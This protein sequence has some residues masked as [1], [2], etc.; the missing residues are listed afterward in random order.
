MDN[1]LYKR[2]NRKMRGMIQVH[3]DF[4]VTCNPSQRKS[5]AE[6]IRI[7]TTVS[8]VPKQKQQV[9]PLISL[10]SERSHINCQLQLNIAWS[11]VRHYL[12]T[13]DFLLQ[14]RITC[15]F[16]RFFVFLFFPLIFILQ[17]SLDVAT[18]R[19]IQVY[20][21]VVVGTQFFRTCTGRDPENL[22]KGEL[23]L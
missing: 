11:H 2:M 16:L 7:T 21:H 3:V 18:T 19:V 9:W 22:R 4:V 23:Q 8:L 5:E 1:L 14:G 13:I 6:V 17:T 15:L 10:R 20:I 12:L